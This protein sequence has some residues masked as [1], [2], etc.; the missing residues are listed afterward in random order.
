MSSKAIITS[1]LTGVADFFEVRGIMLENGGLLKGTKEGISF[2]TVHA[3][4]EIGF[5]RNRED[6]GLTT[7]RRRMLF[8]AGIKAI[9]LLY[10]VGTA[11]VKTYVV[12]NAISVTHADQE[13]ADPTTRD[14]DTERFTLYGTYLGG[15]AGDISKELKWIYAKE[16][17]SI[18]HIDY[19]LS[20]GDA[21][22]VLHVE[23]V[24]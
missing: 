10:E 19:L 23:S 20:T 9:G 3:G 15:T 8:P 21:S 1:L 14:S 16:G 17:E 2:T 5:P 24:A 11:A 18:D 13:L 7:T 6:T 22:A 4:S 12:V